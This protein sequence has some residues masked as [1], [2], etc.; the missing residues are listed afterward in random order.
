M[1]SS[2]LSFQRSQDEILIKN[3]RYATPTQTFELVFSQ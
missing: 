3:F 1:K 2:F